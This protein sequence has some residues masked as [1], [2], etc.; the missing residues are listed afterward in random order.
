[1]ATA[2]RKAVNMSPEA[3]FETCE[4]QPG[5]TLP[6]IVRPAVNGINLASCAGSNRDFITGHLLKHGGLLFRGFEVNS[7]DDFQQFIKNVSGEP[8]EYRE[9]SSPRH[10]VSANVYTSTD[11]PAD[12]SI[13]LHNENSY[14]YTWPLKIFFFC[15]TPAPQGGETPLADTRKVFQ[16]ISPEIREHFIRKKIKY[17][18][19]FGH[20]LGLS[21]QTVFQADDKSK[22]EAYC[23]NTG[24]D[25]EW[26]HGD[27]LRISRI[28]PA[29]ARHPLT[30]EILWFNHATFFHVSTLQP[31]VRQALLEEFKE[32]DLPNNTYYGD[33]SPIEPL[34]LD[35]LRD[36][37]R[38]ETVIFHSERGDVLMLDNMLTAHGR[39][40]FR[41][42][43]S[44]LAGMTEPCSCE[45]S[46]GD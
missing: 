27:R 42:A 37:Y 25:V 28:G 45:N 43:R 14:A 40:P 46:L 34:V 29:V 23:R 18:R 7:A 38:Q 3:L 11:H 19:N 24:Y 15:M 26:K 8:L 17:V 4:V 22:V 1:L 32:E 36:V 12:Q 10:P 2:R 20:G 13:F 6:L 5:Q 41:G 44:V 35:H 30:G 16:R 33:G 9:R 31:S 21:W 39:M